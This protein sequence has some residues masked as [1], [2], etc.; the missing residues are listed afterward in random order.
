MVFKQKLGQVTDEQRQALNVVLRNTDR[1]DNLIR[2]IL[3]VSRLESGTMK[4]VPEKTDVEKI[5]KEANE[6]MQPTADLKNIKINTEIEQNIPEMI[7]DHERI[8][9]V[10]IN[11]VNNAVKFSPNGSIINVRAKKDNDQILF[12][13]QDYGRG[14]PKDKQEKIF[15]IFYQV[16]SGMDRKFG[17]AGL[18]LAISRGIILSHGGKIWVDSEP[19]KGSIFYF[20]L[21]ITPVQDIEGKFRDIDIFKLKDTKRAIEN[22]LRDKTIVWDDTAEKR[23]DM[24]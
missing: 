23:G 12:E 15:E 18:G 6:T 17:G 4:F 10:I 16:D 8:K 14:I 1:L 3:D 11:I 24:Q 2:D 5:I 22:D 13:I 9:Q 20:S 21:P 19:E 7:V